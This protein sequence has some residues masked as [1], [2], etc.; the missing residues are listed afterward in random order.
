MHT[1]GLVGRDPD[2]RAA[3]MADHH[4]PARPASSGLHFFPAFSTLLT[5]HI[6]AMVR[7]PYVRFEPKDA[8]AVSREAGP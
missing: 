1:H 4:R 5:A 7:G 6:A 3:A 8:A 2:R